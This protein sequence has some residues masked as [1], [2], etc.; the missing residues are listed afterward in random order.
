MVVVDGRIFSTFERLVTSVFFTLD[1]CID[2]IYDND[3]KGKNFEDA[4]R[5]MLK[6][7]GLIVLPRSVEIFEPVIPN[8]IA[9][10]LWGKEKTRTDLD[11]IA[12]KGNALLIIECKDAKFQLSFLKQGN[13][14]R[15]FVVEQYYRVQWIRDNFA[16]F[17]SYVQNEFANAGINLSQ[18]FFLFPLVVS[19]TLVNIENFEGAPLVTYS[20]L[21]DIVSKEWNIKAD[22]PSKEIVVETG[23]RLYHLPWFTKSDN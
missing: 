10:K 9:L 22:D 17:A 15:N 18:E 13:K 2:E 14:F 8:D 16:R 4:S 23:G 5:K 19:N 7:K 21:E 11:I 12:V 3:L 6:E 1:N 20:E